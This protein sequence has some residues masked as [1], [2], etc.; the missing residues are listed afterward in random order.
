[1]NYELF[2]HHG[3]EL[4]FPVIKDEITL[5]RERQGT[6][7]TLSFTVV[8]D[9]VLNFTEGDAVSFKVDGQKVFFGFVFTKKRDKDQFIEVTAYSQLRYLK[10]T[11]TYVYTNK[12][13]RDVILMIARDFNLRVGSLENTVYAIPKQIE[14]G[15][16]L[17]DIILNAI[18]KTLIATGKSYVLYDDFGE[19]T[20][21]SIDNMV[22]DLLIDAETGENFSYSSSIDENTYNKIKLSYKNEGTGVRDIYIAQDGNHINEWGVLQYFETIDKSVTN[23]KARANGLLNLY[24]S[25]TRKLEIN[26]AFGDIRVRGGSIIAVALDLGDTILKNQMLVEKVIHRFEHDHYNMDLTLKGGEFVA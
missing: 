11:D 5:T 26:G 8:K 7:E 14:D 16:T 3:N 10:N 15:S 23:P 25:K 1:M 12:T 22:L 4:V 21:K 6:P 17:F 24:N 13:A 9:E 2:I 20:L 19:L 18:D